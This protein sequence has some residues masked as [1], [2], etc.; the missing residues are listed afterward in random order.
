M[1]RFGTHRFLWSWS[2]P[3]LGKPFKESIDRYRSPGI[4]SWRSRPSAFW[5]NGD[6]GA[7]CS[8]GLAGKGTS[9]SEAPTRAHAFR[10][11]GGKAGVVVTGSVIR[12]T[13]LA[14]LDSVASLVIAALIGTAS[15]RM[16]RRSIDLAMDAVPEG[17]DPRAVRAYLGSVS[18]VTE[19]TDL[20]IWAMSTTET[21][22]TAHLVVPIDCDLQAIIGGLHERVRH[23]SFDDSSRPRRRRSRLSVR[24]LRPAISF[25]ELEKAPFEA[26]SVGVPGNDRRNAE[27][28]VPMATITAPA[29]Q[30]APSSHQVEARYPRAERSTSRKRRPFVGIQ[31]QAQPPSMRWHTRRPPCDNWQITLR[32]SKE[33]GKP[34]RPTTGLR[35]DVGKRTRLKMKRAD[36]WTC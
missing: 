29:S 20:H 32:T 7:D 10:C 19:V 36:S 31:A 26:D 9:T 30:M 2:E 13:G 11:A 8:P 21:A 17:I 34:S 3:S 22:L 5:I 33:V 23:P 14:V 4:P 15:W 28:E 18:G 12:A 35:P 25:R 24:G 1:P 6:G 16:L 27:P